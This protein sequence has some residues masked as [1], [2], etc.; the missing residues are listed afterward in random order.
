MT[1]HTAEDLRFVRRMDTKLGIEVLKLDLLTTEVLG[2]ATKLAAFV[3]V[4]LFIVESV[5]ST[6]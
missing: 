6:S 3:L 5:L 2:E 1:D 4:A